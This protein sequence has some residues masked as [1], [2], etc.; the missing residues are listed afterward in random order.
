MKILERNLSKE[1]NFEFFEFF[2][3]WALVSNPKPK[4][5]FEKAVQLLIPA[6]ICLFN[7][8]RQESIVKS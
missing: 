7:A 6:I 4:I 2:E 1:A 5:F 8:S 3:F